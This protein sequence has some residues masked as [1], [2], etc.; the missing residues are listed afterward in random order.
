M[1]ILAL[2]LAPLAGAIHGVGHGVGPG[3]VAAGAT[4]EHRQGMPLKACDQCMA[5]AQIQPAPASAPVV[6]TVAKVIGG[7]FE[8]TADG[9]AARR[10]DAFRSR[11]PP[12]AA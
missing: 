11:G 5:M 10:P 9:L 12:G 8:V 4:H 1:L 6:L 3:S 7:G 2:V